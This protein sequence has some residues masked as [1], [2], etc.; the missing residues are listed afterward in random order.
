MSA[1]NVMKRR[2]ELLQRVAVCAEYRLDTVA[3]VIDVCGLESIPHIGDF[4][5]NGDVAGIA[6]LRGLAAEGYIVL[7]SAGSGRLDRIAITARGLK[8][9]AELEKSWWKK[10]GRRIGAT[11]QRVAEVLAGVDAFAGREVVEQ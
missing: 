1:V 11:V 5:V 6:D 3:A 10:V 2:N 7:R 4:S 9:V 8:V